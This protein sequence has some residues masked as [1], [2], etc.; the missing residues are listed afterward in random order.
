MPASK[1]I[2][3]QKSNRLVTQGALERAGGIIV[4]WWDGAFLSNGDYAS[5][6]FFMKRRR[7]CRC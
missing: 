4:E 6:L 2:N 1:P 5:K 3:N 7:R